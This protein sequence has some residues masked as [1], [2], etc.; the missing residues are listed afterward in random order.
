MAP[1][2]TAADD[3]GATLGQLG[4][5]GAAVEESLDSDGAVLWLGAV[6][7]EWGLS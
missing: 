1:D 6:G 2:K 3:V 7:S 4:D 5:D